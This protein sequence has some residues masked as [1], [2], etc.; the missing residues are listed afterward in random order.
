M[1]KVSISDENAR[2]NIAMC[3]VKRVLQYILYH[4]T[5]TKQNKK[6]ASVGMNRDATDR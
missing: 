4:E 3:F 5:K 1:I 6:G 2:V